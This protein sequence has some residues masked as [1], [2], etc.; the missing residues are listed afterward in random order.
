[1]HPLSPFTEYNVRQAT[2]SDLT[3]IVEFEIEIAKISFPK[4]PIINPEVHTKKIIKAI[5]KEPEGMFVLEKDHEV[6]GWLWITLNTNFLTSEK[7]ATFRSFAIAQQFRGT[8]LPESFFRFGLEY[9][10]SRGI[11]KIT[12][13]VHVGNAA[14]R[15]LYKKLGFEPQ[16]LTME[17]DLV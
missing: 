14:M 1:M 7:Y 13:K 5:D 10:R 15:V 3:K 16:H 2:Q 9:C 12:G 4:E 17:I 8:D 11:F 6:V